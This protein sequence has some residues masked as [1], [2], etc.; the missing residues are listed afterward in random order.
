MRMCAESYFQY[1]PPTSLSL[2][3]T[4]IGCCFI[5][6]ENAYIHPCMHMYGIAAY[7]GGVMHGLWAYDPNQPHGKSGISSQRFKGE[8]ERKKGVCAPLVWERG[9]ARH[10]R[11]SIDIAV[12]AMHAAC[13]QVSGQASCC[14]SCTQHTLWC[15]LVVCMHAHPSIHACICASLRS[16]VLVSHL[17]HTRPPYNQSGF[18]SLSPSAY[19][20]EISCSGRHEQDLSKT[21]HYVC[22]FSPIVTS[23]HFCQFDHFKYPASTHKKHCT[24]HQSEKLQTIILG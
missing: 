9:V 3:P 6:M 14:G 18:L 19:I 24:S 8:K 1:R 4:C 12:L 5:V 17:T 21:Q 20:S 15:L 2:S 7:G 23:E 11:L 13:L 16:W 10:Y 22:V